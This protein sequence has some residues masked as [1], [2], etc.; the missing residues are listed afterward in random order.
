MSVCC[1]NIIIFII[2]I[3][4]I[5]KN[6]NNNSSRVGRETRKSAESSETCTQLQRRRANIFLD[7]AC[8]TPLGNAFDQGF[9]IG[10]VVDGVETP[11]IR[12]IAGKTYRFVVNSACNHPFYLTNTNSSRGRGIGPISDGFDVPPAQSNPVICAG[13]SILWQPTENLIGKDIW[14]QSTA[15]DNMGWLVRVNKL[16][17]CDKY[18]VAPFANNKDLILTIV[19]AVIDRV[20]APTSLVLEYFDGTLGLT[21]FDLPANVGKLIALRDHLV[22]FLGDVLGC[23]DGS[24]PAYSGRGM[25][26]V[27]ASLPITGVDYD[28]FNQQ[29]IST[30]ESAGFASVDRM[31]VL[32]LLNSPGV[33]GAICN[34]GDGYFDSICNKYTKMLKKSNQE[35]IDIVFNAAFGA[36]VAD[37]LQVPFF[38]GT[39]PPGS[40]NFFTN[41]AKLTKLKADFGAFLGRADVLGCTDIT[42]PLANIDF[43][44]LKAVHAAMPIDTAVFNAFNDDIIRGL[45]PLGLHAADLITIRKVLNSTEP[46]ICNQPGCSAIDNNAVKAFDLSVAQKPINHQYFGQGF[47]SAFKLDG[48]FVEGLVL[49]VGKTYA[50]KASQGCL[51]RSTSRTA[52]AAPVRSTLTT[53]SP[54]RTLASRS[55]TAKC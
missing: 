23:T 21:N 28:F 29:I 3:I 1:K 42:F 37:P 43:A 5:I 24:I 17:L 41:A 4:I 15:Q 7:N 26:E 12:V 14:Y 10:F 36:V 45:T 50:F 52:P 6:N 49:E 48:Q 33:R 18:T 35:L 20:L 32:D 53:A 2:I 16:S 25:K 19:E 39:K 51:H 30:L 54:R 40:T 55:A 8:E 11:E 27:H 47:S 13:Q 9:P 44:G 38:N 34:V 22:A 31:F 46:L